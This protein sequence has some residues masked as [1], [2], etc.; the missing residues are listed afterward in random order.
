MAESYNN[1]M[2]SLKFYLKTDNIKKITLA[3]TLG[4]IFYYLRNN[5]KRLEVNLLSLKLRE[6][7]KDKDFNSYAIS[8]NLWKTYL[9][10]AQ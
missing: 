4:W 9:R 6:A 1:A 10:L 7:I 2:S 5:E 8:L 3:N